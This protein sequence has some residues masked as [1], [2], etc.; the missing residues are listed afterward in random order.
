MLMGGQQGR[1]MEGWPEERLAT[2]AKGVLDRMFGTDTPAAGK[3]S[4][5]PLA[6]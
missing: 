6:P 5:H 2:W 3:T 4:G 1:D